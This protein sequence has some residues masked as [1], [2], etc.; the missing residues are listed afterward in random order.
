MHISSRDNSVDSLRREA[1]PDYVA[2]QKCKSKSQ[3]RVGHGILDFRL[4]IC[5][6]RFAASQKTRK[7]A[8]GKR[9]S[10][11]GALARSQVVGLLDPNTSCLR[12]A[13]II[14]TRISS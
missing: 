4:A 1:V 8:I 11:P 5:D 6:F 13:Y 10:T 14:R 2:F 7:S 12:N 3:N 9:Q